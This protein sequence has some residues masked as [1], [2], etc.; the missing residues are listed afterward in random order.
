MDF[1]AE[2]VV[3]LDLL[4]LMAAVCTKD[5]VQQ[6]TSA[7]QQDVKLGQG[8]EKLYSQLNKVHDLS[9]LKIVMMND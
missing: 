4:Y 1:K 9:V 7:E 6:C 3:T 2:L 8:L 5:K